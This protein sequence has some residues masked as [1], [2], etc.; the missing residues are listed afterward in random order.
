MPQP[1]GRRRLIPTMWSAS[2]GFPARWWRSSIPSAPPPLSRNPP[3]T[4]EVPQGTSTFCPFLTS[5][6]TRPS[7]TLPSRSLAKPCNGP[8]SSKTSAKSPSEG[9][10]STVSRASSTKTGSSSMQRKG[11]S[12]VLRTPCQP[13]S[14]SIRRNSPHAT[15]P[16]PTLGITIRTTA[17]PRCSLRFKRRSGWNGTR[18]PSNWSTPIR[19]LPRHPSRRGRCTRCPSALPPSKPAR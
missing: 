1:P 16:T 5:N 18:Q 10:W 11:S 3:P 13:R 17:V 6:S 12:G 4:T 7:R 14:V 2:S 19:R 8:C 15:C 9:R